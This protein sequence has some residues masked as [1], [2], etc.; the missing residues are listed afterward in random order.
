MQTQTQTI[1][2]KHMTTV[3]LSTPQLAQQYA[4]RTGLQYDR[5]GNS[6]VC[7]DDSGEP[8]YTIKFYMQRTELVD[9]RTVYEIFSP[10]ANRYEEYPT[11]ER[12]LED[13]DF[14]EMHIPYKSIRSTYNNGAILVSRELMQELFALPFSAELLNLQGHG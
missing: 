11:K 6:F 13:L 5:K 10:N 4:E 1:K 8:I 3:V 12:M 14:S 9:I 2:T 7:Y